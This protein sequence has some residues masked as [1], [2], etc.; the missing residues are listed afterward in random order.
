M[1]TIKGANHT[2]CLNHFQTFHSRVILTQSAKGE[3]RYTTRCKIMTDNQNMSETSMKDGQYPLFKTASRV[4]EMFLKT[5]FSLCLFVRLFFFYKILPTNLG[6]CKPQPFILL[7]LYVKSEV[8]QYFL[9]YRPQTECSISQF[10]KTN[11]TQS[12]FRTIN[13]GL[14]AKPFKKFPKSPIRPAGS[15][16]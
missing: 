13:R 6:V 11:C 5:L 10:F 2:P 16:F 9:S 14:L 4:S 7:I 8:K 15:R 12:I 3:K 1:Q